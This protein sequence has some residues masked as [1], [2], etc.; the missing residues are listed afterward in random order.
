MYTGDGASALSMHNGHSASSRASPCLPAQTGAA[1][2]QNLSACSQS[3]PVLSCI[4]HHFDVI[5]EALLVAFDRLPMPICMLR[6]ARLDTSTMAALC[7][8]QVPSAH[9]PLEPPAQ[10]ERIRWGGESYHL[11]EADLGLPLDCPR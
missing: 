2:A 5:N 3:L 10:Q 1:L 4:L 8:R 6:A 11:M 7:P 9:C